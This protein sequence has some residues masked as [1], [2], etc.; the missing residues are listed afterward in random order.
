MNELNTLTLDGVTYKITDT[1]AAPAG[2]GLGDYAK[3]IT[4]EDLNTCNKGGAFVFDTATNMPGAFNGWCYMS[5]LP[6][7]GHSATQTVWGM[8]E[9]VG[10]AMQRVKHDWDDDAWSAWE[11]INPPMALGVEYRTTERFLGRPVYVKLVDVGALPSNSYKEVLAVGSCSPEA[12]PLSC[13]LISHT[14]GATKRYS[15][16]PEVQTYLANY[17]GIMYIQITTTADCSDQTQAYA[18][19]K[20]TRE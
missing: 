4:G 15:Q 6:S 20:Y 18:I 12:M 8:L 3:T 2:Y 19:V 1:A 14:T 13:S 10:C 5:V 7:N 17:S 9:H 11:W 16:L